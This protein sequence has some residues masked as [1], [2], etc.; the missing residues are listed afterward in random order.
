MVECKTTLSLD[1]MAQAFHWQ[2][3][4]HWASVAIPSPKRNKRTGY[5]TAS[6][7]RELAVKLL[8]ARGVGIVTV[9]ESTKEEHPPSL[10]RWAIPGHKDSVPG[11]RLRWR[12]S[13]IRSLRGALVP[14]QKNFEAAGSSGGR[15]WS[16]WRATCER[17]I[18]L[19]AH[20]PGL[21]L[22]EL[23]DGIDHHYA[24]DASARS[25][26]S[27]WIQRGRIPEIEVRREGRLIK[28]YPTGS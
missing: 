15:H 5:R 11:V 24:S 21:S 8:R 27:H 19:V 12:L 7:G 28:L 25:A 22:K 18:R 16:E 4:A 26:M 2:R 10:C 3:Y 17:A 14:E 9:G 23:I 1:L 13:D 20:N 6:K